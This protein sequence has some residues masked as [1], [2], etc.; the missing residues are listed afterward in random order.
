MKSMLRGM[1]V[2]M[3]TGHESARFID[4]GTSVKRALSK[5]QIF[6]YITIQQ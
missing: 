6:L 5:V 4:N 3:G 2:T 1:S